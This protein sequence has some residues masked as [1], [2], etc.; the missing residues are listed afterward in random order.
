MES[1]ES[2][3]EYS[4]YIMEHSIT[5]I[6]AILYYITPAMMLPDAAEWCQMLLYAVRCCQ[7]HMQHMYHMQHAAY[8]A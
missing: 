6:H 4:Y 1:L 2:K 5:L 3:L 7:K 8:V